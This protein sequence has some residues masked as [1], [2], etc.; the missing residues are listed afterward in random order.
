MSLNYLDPDQRISE[1]HAHIYFTA[2]TR[3]SAA[4]LREHLMRRT[5]IQI[6]VHSLADGPRGPHMTSMFGIDI[7]TSDLAKVVGFLML[8]HGPHPVLIHPVT[9]RERDDHSVHAL[10]LGTPQPL[11]LD[12]L[13]A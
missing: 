12:C 5:D 13:E 11:D 10:W 3:P 2:A 1:F 8:N 6:K 9:A 4:S 7:P